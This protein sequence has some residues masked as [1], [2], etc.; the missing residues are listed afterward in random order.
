MRCGNRSNQLTIW[1]YFAVIGAA[2]A[3]FL[4]LAGCSAENKSEL[5]KKLEQSELH[6]LGSSCKG[7]FFEIRDGNFSLVQFAQKTVL[8]R[9]IRISDSGSNRAAMIASFNGIDIITTISVNAD[10]TVAR[11]E[12]VKFSPEPTA[13]QLAKT[14]L[15]PDTL[16]KMAKDIEA[17][18]PMVLC[19]REPDR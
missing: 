19:P 8:Q 15:A 7:P 3:A 14:K 1:L 4:G 9:A 11:I 16:F 10:M 17:T 13:E 2:A 6:Q 12:S 5:V 18:P